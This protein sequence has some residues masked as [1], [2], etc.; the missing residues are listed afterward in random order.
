M[1]NRRCFMKNTLAA[2]ALLMSGGAV[3]EPA[4]RSVCTVPYELDMLIKAGHI[5]GACC[6]KQ[7]V[8]LSH[9]LG[10]AKIGW[11][12]KLLKTV[13]E[14]AHLGDTAFANGKIYGAFVIYDKNLRK[15][16][17]TG[18]VR[19]WN[20]NLEIV[21]EKWFPEAFDGITVLGDTVY[22]GIDRWGRPMHPLCCVKRLSLDLE[23][24]GNVDVDLGFEIAY[25]VQT[26]S[27]DGKD[28][29]FGCYGGTAR[30]SP[31]FKKVEKVAFEC[32]EGF[33]LVPEQVAK[34]DGKV[35]FAVR[36]MGGNMQGWR[37]D[38]VN[39]PPRIRLDFYRL[40]N[41]KFVKVSK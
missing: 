13:E 22:V 32:S 28:L 21:A 18:L 16:G 7:G 5:Q 36:A 35:F 12:G 8:Y 33:D 19:V 30:V 37:K 17:M 26:M 1:I 34:V 20:E 11:D 23:D 15:N 25:G 27:N 4:M 29:Y 40:E 6:S 2:A 24:K 9:Q 41:G 38:P 39:N 3:A 10:I 14:P 31:D